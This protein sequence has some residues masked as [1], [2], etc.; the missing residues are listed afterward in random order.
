M[1]A[2]FVQFLLRCFPKK[3]QVSDGKRPHFCLDLIWKKG[4]DFVWFFKIGCHLCQQFVGRYAYIYGESQ[5]SVY[6]V[7]DLMGGCDR[8][9]IK[10]GHS[11]HIEKNFIDGKGFHNRCIRS[12]DFFERSGAFHIKIKIALYDHELRAFPKC[13]CHRFSCLD[14]VFFCRNGF[15]YYDSGTLLR[16]T[17]NACRNVPKIRQSLVYPSHGFPG[18]K[19]AVY[20][21]MK[22]Q[23]VHTYPFL[24]L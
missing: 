11:C 9:R 13:H 24:S 17:A 7:F 4:V 2:D 21:Y 8:V 12:A 1:D 14:S 23:T 20:I 3:E 15:G 16:I 6:P 19:R 10:Q 18:K 5:F 22:N